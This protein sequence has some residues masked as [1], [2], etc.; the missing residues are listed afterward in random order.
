MPIISCALVFFSSRVAK[1]KLAYTIALTSLFASAPVA[2]RRRTAAPDRSSAH[3]VVSY[4]LVYM[5]AV[6]LLPGGCLGKERDQVW[7]QQRDSNTT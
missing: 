7:K 5:D 1:E 3:P 6:A 4:P 2:W